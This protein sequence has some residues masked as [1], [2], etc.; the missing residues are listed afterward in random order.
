MGV[1]TSLAIVLCLAVYMLASKEK[2]VNVGLLT[3]R[4]SGC[5]EKSSSWYG[6]G[7]GENILVAI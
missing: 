6:I 7:A 2:T 3:C 4:E 1:Y 5:Q